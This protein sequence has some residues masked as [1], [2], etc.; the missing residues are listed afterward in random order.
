MSTAR[1]I[2]LGLTIG[3][4]AC[5]LGFYFGARV[6]GRHWLDLKEF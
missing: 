2:A 4:I 1:A 5:P 6:S 3:S